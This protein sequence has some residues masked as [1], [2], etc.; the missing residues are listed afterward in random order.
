MDTLRA[1]TLFA[2][3]AAAGSFQRVAVEQAISPQAVSKAIGQLERHLGVR[4]FH[5]TTRR[6]SLT[7]DGLA[8]LEAVNPGLVA[9]AAAVGGACAATESIDGPIRITAP[10]FARKVLVLPIAEFVEQHPGVRVELV[11][12]DAFTD[13][14]AAKIDIGLRVGTAPSGQV[15][16][17]RLFQVQQRLCAAPAYL[18]RYGTP[19]SLA[20]LARHRCTGFRLATTGRL[21]AWR[22]LVDDELRQLEMPAAFCS[23]DADTELDAVLAGAGIALIDSINGAAEVRAGR[24]VPVLPTLRGEEI[25]CQ[26]Y[27]AQRTHLPRRVRACIDHLV[28]RLQGSTDFVFD[29]DTP[30]AAPTK[31]ARK[32]HA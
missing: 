29:T 11:M 17:R 30:G 20:E 22:L 1:I 21:V 4:L 18:A 9:I 23:N 24:L 3:A 12:D 14:V 2:D 8:F 7:A 19:A 28:Q 13:I 25:G 10:R 15:I 16:A 31:G 26:L 32:K 5:R 27:Y 6:S